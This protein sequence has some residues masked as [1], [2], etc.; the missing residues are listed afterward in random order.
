MTIRLPA[1]QDE[2]LEEAILSENPLQLSKDPYWGTLWEAAPKTAGAILRDA[3]KRKL[4]TLELG[5]GLGVPGIAALIKGHDVTFSD[6]SAAAVDL[7]IA[8]ARLNG[9]D[10]A[11]G[12]VFD[13][14]N[15]PA[16]QFELI[17]ASDILYDLES[18]EPL[19]MTLQTMLTATGVAW[20]GDPGRANSLCF[21]ELARQNDWYIDTL[22][23]FAQSNPQPVHAKFRILV[24]KR[25]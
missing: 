18:H 20:I 2:L 1:S 25:H 3:W 12:L 24:I 10:E 8:N 22:D 9:F 14:N 11:R 5:C 4:N 6:R 17:V 19:L 7:S 13:W 15:P 16:D 21:A 23:E